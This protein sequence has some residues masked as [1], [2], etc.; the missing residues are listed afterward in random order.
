MG[1]PIDLPAPT[2][3]IINVLASMKVLVSR[4]AEALAEDKMFLENHNI[5]TAS[6]W[7]SYAVSNADPCLK[8]I[9]A[10]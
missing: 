6:L 3:C 4:S 2:I 7:T 1:S 5:T 9:I 10:Q 8:V